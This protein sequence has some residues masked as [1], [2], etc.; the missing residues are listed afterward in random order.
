M[1]ETFGQLVKRLRNQARLSQEKLAEASDLSISITLKIERDDKN[2]NAPMAFRTDTLEKLANGLG[3]S[4]DSPDRKLLFETHWERAKQHWERKRR[5]PRLQEPVLGENSEGNVPLIST[6][7]L[8]Q[9]LVLTRME[10]V[11]EC[12]LSMLTEASKENLGK[13]RAEEIKVTTLG[14]SSIFQHL[15]RED[16]WD[17]AIRSVMKDGKRR[18]ISVYR[19]TGDLKRAIDVIQEIRNLSI[20]PS[21]YI[22]KYFRS[23]GAVR[24]AYNLLIIPG[25]GALWGLSTHNPDV[26]DAAFFYPDTP[27]FE[28]HIRL[29]IEHFTTRHFSRADVFHLT[30]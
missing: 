26:I 15:E 1:G 24:P 20:Y 23:V 9:Q 6:F 14:R 3:L 11:A 22:P 4:E 5:I 27:A 12:V 18:V 19:T 13:S 17:Q 16:D 2:K 21:Q 10:E 30:C 25:V 8:S 7:D 29:L 28:Q